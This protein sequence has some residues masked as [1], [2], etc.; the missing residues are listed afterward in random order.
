MF[1]T[2]AFDN[3]WRSRHSLSLSVSS[4]G[5]SL[6]PAGRAKGDG[7][8]AGGDIGGDAGGDSLMGGCARTWCTRPVNRCV[9]GVV[10]ALYGRFMGVEDAVRDTGGDTG[11]DTR[12]PGWQAA[13]RSAPQASQRADAA[14]R[15]PPS[16]ER[17]RCHTRYT[18]CPGG[19]MARCA[20]PPQQNHAVSAMRTHSTFCVAAARGRGGEG[21]RHQRH[22]CFRQMCAALRGR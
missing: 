9:D 10:A 1:H 14:P 6:S 12:A 22:T 11:G 16:S 4:L 15:L 13:Q 7:Y 17:T 3:N 20:P 21:R 8:N 2:K 18:R 19:R 5:L